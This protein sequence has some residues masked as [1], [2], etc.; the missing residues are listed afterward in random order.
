[1]EARAI[2]RL[3]APSTVVLHDFGV[4]GDDNP[5]MVLEYI[6]GEELGVL[7]AREGAMRPERAV[8]LLTQLLESLEEAHTEDLLHRDIK[9]GNILV[10]DYLSKHKR[11]KLLDFGLA[12]IFRDE[13]TEGQNVTKDGQLLGTPRYMSPEQILNPEDLTQASDVYALGLVAMEMLTG[14]QTV[15][16]NDTMSLL[17]EQVSTTPFK[18][19]AWLRIIP[20]LREI[21]D[22][23]VEK[24]L[25]K[26]FQTAAEVLE[27]LH[28]LPKVLSLPQ[29]PASKRDSGDSSY[30]VFDDQ[31]ISPDLGDT[32]E[33]DDKDTTLDDGFI[34]EELAA[35]KP[36]YERASIAVLLLLA[37]VLF[38]ALGV[39][40]S[41]PTEDAKAPAAAGGTAQVSDEA[42]SRSTAHPPAPDHGVG[43][44]LPAPD[45][46]ESRA[47][48][49]T[50]AAKPKD[51]NPADK[52][53]PRRT[54]PRRPPKKKKPKTQ[55][56]LKLKIFG[57][58]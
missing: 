38:I 16:G 13:E 58:E 49:G 53:K 40:S 30:D 20:E 14:Q 17:G 37:V 3:K 23:M 18:L 27:A 39:A 25:D 47:A 33:L 10:F 21:I 52:K 34:E 31:P 6:D 43:R 50:K 55:K 54:T 32:E 2:S 1:R 35:M 24:N 22:C 28:E 51:N 45:D 44:A 57:V 26:R 7:L 5:Y 48:P 19:P 11:V 46:P 36:D 42:A 4:T 56:P 12:K 8:D 29:P 15:Q 9:P 41:G